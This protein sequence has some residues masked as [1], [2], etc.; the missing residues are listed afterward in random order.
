MKFFLRKILC[1]CLA[2]VIMASA[3]SCRMYSERKVADTQYMEARKEILSASRPMGSEEYRIYT[4]I[5]D[6]DAGDHVKSVACFADGSA[7]LYL[8]TGEHY[9]TPTESTATLIEATQGFLQKMGDHLDLA[10]WQAK[11]D[12]SLPDAGC[13]MLYL[14]TD[15]GIYTLSFAPAYMAEST[16]IAQE[17]Y[18]AYMAVYKELNLAL[19]IEADV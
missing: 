9:E 14:L 10:R 11:T 19:G 2:L 15:D 12:L 3:V 8:S 6:M 17:L 1:L 16:E 7:S 4:A 18:S 5:I 13:D